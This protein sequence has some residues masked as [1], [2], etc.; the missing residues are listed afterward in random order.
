VLVGGVLGPIN[1]PEVVIAGRCRDDGE[2]HEQYPPLDSG[3]EQW[4]AG[5]SSFRGK[6]FPHVVQKVAVTGQVAP[7]R[8]S[9]DVACSRGLL[10]IRR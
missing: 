5:L 1:R 7:R 10:A 8:P 6:P 2:F 3:C 9:S 4:S